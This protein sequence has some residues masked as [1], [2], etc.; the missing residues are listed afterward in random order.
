MP[1]RT[2]VLRDGEDVSS[3]FKPWDDMMLDA[4]FTAAYREGSPELEIVEGRT[5]ADTETEDSLIRWTQS[6]MFM[7]Y[8][9]HGCDVLETGRQTLER[10]H[11]FET[12]DGSRRIELKAGDV[13]RAWRGA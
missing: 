8:I 9:M 11:T 1:L 3:Q 13:L 10:D 6:P 12:D 2:Q 7:P 5:M 4:F